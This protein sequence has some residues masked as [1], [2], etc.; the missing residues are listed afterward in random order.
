MATFT[1][2]YTLCLIQR[3]VFSF[4]RKSHREDRGNPLLELQPAAGGVC[5]RLLNIDDGVLETAAGMPRVDRL[6]FYFRREVLASALPGF[7]PATVAAD[8][9]LRLSPR[10]STG[11]ERAQGTRVR[12]VQ[13]LCR[14]HPITDIRLVA[15]TSAPFEAS[16]AEGYLH[17]D[18][19]TGPARIYG[20]EIF[21]IHFGV[22][23]EYQT[24]AVPAPAGSSF[25]EFTMSNAMYSTVVSELAYAV[26]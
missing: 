2:E 20:S 21:E 25:A 14:F 7:P 23:A 24:A 15:A 22:E 19:E 3:D 10:D 18:I 1:L 17:L 16:A 11:T 6:D 26:R 8:R 9:S 13:P 5:W 12:I 4:A